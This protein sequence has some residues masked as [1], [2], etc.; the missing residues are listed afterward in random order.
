M[1]Y[2]ILVTDDLGSGGLEELE[3]ATDTAFDVRTDL[4]K[5]Q[6]L[7]LI[8]GFDALII[9]SSTTVDQEVLAAAGR[10]RVIGRAGA[11]VDNIDV[12]SATRQ[13][14]V[15]TNTPHSSTVATAEQAIALMLAAS[16]HLPAAHASVGAGQWERS[17][18]AGIELSGKTLGVVGFGRVGR[19][20]ASRAAAFG[21]SVV[22]T[23]P[24]V[25]E[26]IGRELGVP[27][28]DLDELLGAADFLSL[29]TSLTDE[30]ESLI[31]AEAI[32]LMKPGITIVNVARG[33]LIDEAALAE[34]LVSGKVRMAAIDVFRQEPPGVD[35]P[36]LGLESVIHTPHLGGSTHEAQADIA[37]QV[38]KQVLDVLRGTGFRNSINLPFH[39]GPDAAGTLAHV[40]LAERMGI[41][42]YVMAGAPPRRV[43][44]EVRGDGADQ[45]V[46]P[47]A[48]GVLKGLLQSFLPESVN[49]VNAPV[50]ADEHG[51]EMA[52]MRGLGTSDYPNLVS[53]RV[54]WEGGERVMSA[55]LFAGQDPRIVQVSDYHLDAK[56]EGTVLLMLNDD[57]PGVIGE[58]GTL[59][60]RHDVNIAEWRL[61]RDR[62]GGKALSFINLD[63]DPPPE[64][65]AAL[66]EISHVL[67]A[68]SVRLS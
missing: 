3:A 41:L 25:S 54:V 31:N 36:L 63:S 52:Q 39:S 58:V 51:I 49:Y 14:V 12:P 60:G 32:E 8:P 40:Q 48:T 33:R 42:Q 46:K 65:L 13:G 21:M 20:V 43:E 53:C 34:A 9:R 47:V 35:N 61:G 2:R 4:S 68:E 66:R 15:V 22:A 59:L 26:T 17:R 16:R 23:D 44:V 18:F 1:M 64:V 50:L 38:V 10:L 11:G 56:P 62:V 30:T 24:F 5:D 67:K 28:V 19:Q 27:L 45:L 37:E 55:V 57:V 29:H 7:E 6:L